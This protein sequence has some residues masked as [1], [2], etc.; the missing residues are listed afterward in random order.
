[1]NQIIV[2]GNLT[3]DPE[4]RTTSTGK[5]VCSFSLA[6]QRNFGDAVDFLNIVTWGATADNCK[7]YLLKGAK[8]AVFG[9]LQTRQYEVDGQK[10]TAYE[11]NASNVEFLSRAE[12]KEEPKAEPKEELKEE[13]NPM[14]TLLNDF[15]D[16][17]PF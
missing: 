7:K 4:L 3:R 2:T 17:L 12:H 10:R 13:E 5:S 9:T 1:M 14:G 15:E 11:I 16:N 8:V 6:V